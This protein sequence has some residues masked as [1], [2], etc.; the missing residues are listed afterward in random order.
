MESQII[1]LRRM[2]AYTVVALW[3]VGC[4]NNLSTNALIGA[5]NNKS[6]IKKYSERKKIIQSFIKNTVI[7]KTPLKTPIIYNRSY[8]KILKG[9]YNRDTYTLKYGDTLFYVAWITG[10]DYHDLA[11]KNNI[12]KPYNLRI[13]QSIQ[14]GNGADPKT[15]STFLDKIQ[16]K[17]IDFK[18]TKRYASNL[19]QKGM[20]SNTNVIVI[21]QWPADGKIIG[22]YDPNSN[23]GI[24]IKGKRNQ[25]IFASANGTV[26][27]AGSAFRGYGNLIIIKHSDDY[28]SAYAHND[29]ILVKAKQEVIAGQKIATMGNTGTDSV[30][31]YFE[32]RYKGK[33]VN[34]LHFLTRR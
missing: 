16:D 5:D 23:K 11:S 27:Y 12:T 29:E 25:S 30:K 4:S 2:M 26:V 7:E 18:S 19:N 33:P 34:P 21:W 15:V 3:L 22:N 31:L 10:R 6:V 1:I 8:N 13:G 14:L 20:S 9:S 24:E 17:K 28:L 32:I